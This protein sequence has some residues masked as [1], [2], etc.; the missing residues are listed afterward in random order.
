VSDRRPLGDDEVDAALASRPAW[1]RRAGALHRELRFPDFPT[2]VAFV[3]RV[4][5]EAER[6][7]HHPDWRNVQDRVWVDL[8]THDVGGVTALDL[9]LADR[10]DEHARALGGG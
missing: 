4:A 7:D 3:V 6:M 5:F 9:A 8:S 2:A 10:I 1:S